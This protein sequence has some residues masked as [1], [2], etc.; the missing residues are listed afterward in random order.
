MV[1]RAADGPLWAVVGRSQCLC[2]R[3]WAV[4]GASLDGP[5]LLSKPL[6]A[7]LGHSRGL[8]ERSWAAIWAAVGDLG[9][10]SRPLG[11]V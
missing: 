6:W 11:A 4:L 2:E 5:G 3:S 10:R 8:C 1:G 9:P 7:V